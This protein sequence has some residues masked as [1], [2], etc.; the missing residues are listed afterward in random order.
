[1]PKFAPQDRPRVAR[2]RGYPMS[3]Q[4]CVS[5]Q[6]TTL[7]QQ[8]STASI[9]WVG[10]RDAR[11]LES[12]HPADGLAR[13]DRASARRSSASIRRCY[14]ANIAASSSSLVNEG[15]CDEQSRLEVLFVN[16]IF[17]ALRQRTDLWPKKPRPFP[18]RPS[19]L[20]TSLRSESH[21]YSQRQ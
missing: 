13:S 11:F 21:S 4:T 20:L 1:M 14:T 7:C 8:K 9:G 15:K 5:H 19:H 18:L 2:Y 17:R 12:C 3:N 16:L 10:L 6:Y